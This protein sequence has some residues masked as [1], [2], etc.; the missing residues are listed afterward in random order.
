M[1]TIIKTLR[2]NA[3][4]TQ[5]ELAD[6]LGTTQQTVAKW[7]K[8]ET[9]PKLRDII[10]LSQ[11]FRVTTDQLL[12]VNPLPPPASVEAAI[13]ADPDLDP[14]TRATLLNVYRAARSPSS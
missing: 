7:E 4:L 12:G 3:G 2:T 10:W 6:E 5:T 13:A 9:N 1:G 11:R 8:G 14:K